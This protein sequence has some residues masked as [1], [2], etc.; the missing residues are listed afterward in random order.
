GPTGAKKV[1]LQ[2]GWAKCEPK[3]GVY[4]FEWLDNIIDE[5][6]AQGV[7]PWL[8]T[9]YGNPIYEGGGY[10]DL[11]GGF[12]VSEEALIAWDKWVMELVK[13]YQGKVN[14]WEIWN[15][16]DNNSK[17]TSEDY[18]RIFIRTAEII[19]DK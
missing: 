4:N 8:Q 7:E 14:I 16:S 10:P 12:P 5:V 9:S 17:N 15:E 18:A 19:R 3:K 2:A 1:R 13:R 6:I 11:S